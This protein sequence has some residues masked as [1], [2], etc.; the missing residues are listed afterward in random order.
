MSNLT[1]T[2]HFIE[3]TDLIANMKEYIMQMNLL[4]YDN[5]YNN[6]YDILL[7]EYHD[8]TDI[9]KAAEK[10]SLSE[11]DSQNYAV[12][13]KSDQ[14]PSFKKLYSMF[15]A[16]LNVLKAY[17]DNAMK[18]DII[19]KLIFSAASLIMFMLKSDSSL[20][21]IIDYRHLNNIII[22]NHYSLSLISDMLNCLQ[23]A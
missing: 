21:L 17:L 9:F 7:P 3:L 18:A 20:W 22:K 11:K 2:E 23:G 12:D 5:K 16:E 8:F 1:I 14:Q 13:L 4:H 19:H 10:Q 6:V 15:S